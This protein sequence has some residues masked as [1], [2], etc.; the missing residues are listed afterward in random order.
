MSWQRASFSGIEF[1]VPLPTKNEVDTYWGKPVDDPYHLYR[2]FFQRMQR[3]LQR[4]IHV[5]AVAD[6]NRLAR[7][8]HGGKGGEKH[9]HV[10]N[11]RGQGQ[12]AIDRGG[13]LPGTRCA[14]QSRRPRAR[15][16]MHN[17]ERR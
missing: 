2:D 12:L 15:L 10:G 9:R 5:P 11:V 1:P 7:Q 14:G 17:F 3:E 16:Q 13:F 8:G 6:H 4:L